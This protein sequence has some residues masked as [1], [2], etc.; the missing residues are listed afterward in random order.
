VT[1]STRT[2]LCWAA[3]A[4]VV[5]A[6]GTVA[7]WVLEAQRR[8]TFLN[9]FDEALTIRMRSTTVTVGPRAHA[10]ARV[11]V[12]GADVEVRGADGRVMDRHALLVPSEDSGHA[13][14]NP[15][16]AAP[17]YQVN[18]VYSSGGDS[19]G[20]G[21]NFRPLAG[22]RFVVVSADYV[23]EEAPERLDVNSKSVYT[24]RQHVGVQDGGWKIALGELNDA[25]QGFP[26]AAALA[27]RIAGALP[28]DPAAGSWA[29]HGT[30]VLEGPSAAAAAALSVLE[31]TKSASW[32]EYAFVRAMRRAGRAAELRL[33]YRAQLSKEPGSADAAVRL[34]RVQSRDEAEPV[35]RAAFAA[36]PDD[37]GV[38]TALARIALQTGRPAEAADLY[39][40][41][42][43]KDDAD[44]VVG[45]PYALALVR[46]GRL[47]EA[48]R[49]TLVRA[50]SKD[51]NAFDVARY[52]QVARVPGAKPPRKTE[53][54][55]AQWAKGRDGAVEWL[56][57]LLGDDPPAKHGTFSPVETVT[58]AIHQAAKRDPER[59]LALCRAAETGALTQLG[60]E[61]TL[62]LTLE[63]WRTGDRALFD[64]LYA[65]TSVGLSADALCAW[66]D[67]GE[68]PVDGW[69][70][71]AGERAAVLLARARRLAAAGDGGEA[72]KGEA[73][74]AD[75]L[76]GLATV[77]ARHWPAPP[78][79]APTVRLVLVTAPAP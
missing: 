40:H 18:V 34:A 27:R 1:V 22:E 36:H 21:P 41:L 79:A 13:I 5:L 25:P 33:A 47:D 9:G 11:R 55:V 60:D 17:L 69:R 59:A 15:L 77:A 75:P 76:A 48:L 10:S 39:A 63:A 8:V 31:Q 51:A 72:A 73:L 44:V 2:K 37:K 58:L 7:I 20:P 35:L 38:M 14:Y 66:V 65:A 52:V 78:R 23:L 61:T 3:A 46:A 30:M 53:E 62:L 71:D 50:T 45:L 74:R 49:V 19:G 67:R 56:A 57:A 4:V 24:V 32:A 28:G 26:R 29:L 54:V 42:A 64:R 6:A 43:E 70:I 68:E 16:G 12:G